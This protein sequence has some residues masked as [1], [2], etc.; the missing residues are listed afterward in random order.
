MSAINSLP[1]APEFVE[2]LKEITLDTTL[3]CLRVLNVPENIIALVRNLDDMGDYIADCHHA[4]E[5]LTGPRDARFDIE[6]VV[7]E[8]INAVVAVGGVFPGLT[9][10]PF[11]RKGSLLAAVE[12]S[13]VEIPAEK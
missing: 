4:P 1:V 5:T 9:G 7:L 6:A 11:A 10:I 13:A 3:E 2:T 12:D 8:T